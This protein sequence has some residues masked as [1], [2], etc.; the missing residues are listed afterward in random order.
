MK[1]RQGLHPDAVN[2]A[3]D[4]LN[5]IEPITLTDHARKLL[6]DLGLPLSTYNV[7]TARRAFEAA[8]K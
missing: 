1:A 3:I 4:V 5:V 6:S 7:D 8:K 2:A